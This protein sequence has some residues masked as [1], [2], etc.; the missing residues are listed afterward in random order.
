LT[1]IIKHVKWRIVLG[2]KRMQGSTVLV[3]GAGIAGLQTARALIKR[4]F[5]VLVLEQS[6]DIGGLWSRRYHGANYGV[7]GRR[8]WQ[9]P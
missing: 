4:G 7:Q 8:R 1:C 5:D 3:V 2:C 6:D 9:L